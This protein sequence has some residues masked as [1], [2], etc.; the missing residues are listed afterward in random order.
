M[1]QAPEP[2]FGSAHDALIFAFNHAGQ[3]SPRTPLAGLLHRGGIGSGKG[4][5]GIE[6][7][8]QAGI[9]L[10]EFE[11]L[12][13]PHQHVLR[14]RF[15]RN[16][17]PCPHCHITG[18]CEEWVQAV[19]ALSRCAELDTLNRQARHL[20]VEK[21]VCGLKG[22]SVAV[23]AANFKLVERTLQK[24]MQAFRRKMEKLENEAMN[25]ADNRLRDM[26]VVG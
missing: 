16:E 2:L 10:A 8:A 13:K 5:H 18:P 14:V 22:I 15:G 19:D 3:H 11:K 24:Q 17:Q 4:L 23:I 26:G 7:A 20:M 25:E 6:A 21:A 9:I 1:P 12:A